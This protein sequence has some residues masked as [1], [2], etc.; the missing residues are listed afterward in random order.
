MATKWTIKELLTSVKLNQ[1]GIR[2]MTDAEQIAIIDADR[3]AGDSFHNLDNKALQV[4]QS[5]TG[6][7]FDITELTN[8]LFRDAT[9]IGVTTP[10]ST[11]Y[12]EQFVNVRGKLNMRVFVTLQYLQETNEAGEVEIVVTDGTTPVTVTDTLS[13]NPAPV[14]VYKTYIVDTTSFTEDDILNIQV[15]LT[16][17]QVEFVEF[18]GV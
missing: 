3:L 15:K 2:R 8:F 17:V 18:R 12:D 9:N 11:V 6:S 7:T 16:Q 4:Y 5:G 14:K 10:K 13:S 1:M